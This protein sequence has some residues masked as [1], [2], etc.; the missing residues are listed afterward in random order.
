M[1]RE[2]D[3]ASRAACSSALAPQALGA[4]DSL[5]SAPHS[6]SPGF[7]AHLA[8]PAHLGW[9]RSL[10]D[11]AAACQL[12]RD[13]RAQPKRARCGD[14]ASSPGRLAAS[15]PTGPRP[16]TAAK[17]ARALLGKP[18]E[19]W[20]KGLVAEERRRRRQNCPGAPFNPRRQ[21]TILPAQSRGTYK[22]KSQEPFLSYAASNRRGEEKSNAQ[23]PIL[24]KQR[25]PQ[26]PV[27]S[28]QQHHPGT[29]KHFQALPKRFG[30]PLLKTMAIRTL[31]QP[32]W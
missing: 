21:T 25:T 27:D 4:V 11:V 8:H 12:A 17:E 20:L 15:A 13:W 30:G 5:D 29:S 9:Q 26:T 19:Q 14:A 1:S 6:T 28:S 2:A 32:K 16:A 24:M 23:F 31:P 18:D 10:S 7:P 22:T 3:A